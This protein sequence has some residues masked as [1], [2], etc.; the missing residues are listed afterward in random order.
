MYS[1]FSETIQSTQPSV[2]L[3]RGINTRIQTPLLVNS[4]SPLV[5]R[6]QRRTLSSCSLLH[7]LSS[8]SNFH[9]ETSIAI[10]SEMNLNL[11]I[12]N[13][14]DG[15]FIRKMNITFFES[16]T[17]FFLNFLDNLMLSD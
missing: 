8:R 15:R 5:E 12:T 10:E 1:L 11:M 4:F 17:V 13:L 16:N 3:K 2:N 6:N 14:L 7:I 9:T